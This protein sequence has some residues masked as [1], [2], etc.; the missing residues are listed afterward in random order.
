MP[1][2]WPSQEVPHLSDL[3][4]TV[5]SPGDTLYNCIAWAAGDN[6]RWWW[7]LPLKGINYWPKGVP[8]E[9]T[10][11]AFIMAFGTMGYVPCADG[12]LVA[13]IEKV[14]LFAKQGLMAIVPTHAALQLA[15]GQWT[16]KLGVFE[17]IVHL[18]PHNVNGPIY[19]Q[20]VRFLSRPRP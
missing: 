2:S 14:A 7:P 5:T 17:D 19:G 20:V 6:T 12:S 8:R 16:S 11:E 13:G 15:T 10:V 1:G 9:Q 3:N 18:T 4:C